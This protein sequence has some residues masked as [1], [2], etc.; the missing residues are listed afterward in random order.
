MDGD[1]VDVGI[2]HKPDDLIGEELSVVLRWQVRLSGLRGVQLETLADSLSEDV[3]RRVGLHDLGHGL[4]DQGLAS[5][6]PITKGTEK[7]KETELLK[8]KW[9]LIF[10]TISLL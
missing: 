8:A 10:E 4:L 7:K 6:E 9:P 5:W 3:Q 2:V 1:S